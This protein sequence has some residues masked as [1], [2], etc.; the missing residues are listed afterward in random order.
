[1]L[2]INNT[3]CQKISLAK[4]K[5]IVDAWLLVYKK[6]N[7]LVSLALV[8]AKR[9]RSINCSYRGVDKATDVLSFSGDNRGK[10]LG[11][12]IINLEEIK[13][14]GKYLE[15]FGAKKS[16]DYIFNFLLVHGLLHL[17]GYNDETEKERQKMISLG[18]KFLAK[19]Y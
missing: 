19:F 15:V 13:K 7:W 14:P 2:E 1:M 17:I 6:S 11:E 3:T 12:I 16:P 8:G 5:K 18:V 10:F 9:M 4:T